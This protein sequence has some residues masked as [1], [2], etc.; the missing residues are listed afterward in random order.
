VGSWAGS[1]AG[2]AARA[3]VGCRKCIE[4]AWTVEGKEWRN[5]PWLEAVLTRVRTF[6][7]KTAMIVAIEYGNGYEA[8]EVLFDSES[9]VL[10]IDVSG[11]RD[12]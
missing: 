12:L 9:P 4:N 5:V 10:E 1:S 7:P 6:D 8:Y 11:R 3:V 2:D